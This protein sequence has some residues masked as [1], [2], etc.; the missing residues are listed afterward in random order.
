MPTDLQE[1]PVP[2]GEISQ[3]PNAFEEFLDRNQKNL[4]L[5]SILLALA[6]A[7]YVIYTGI[8]QS[9]QDTA[10]AAL[11]EADK[12]AELQAVIQQ[13]S[14]TRAAGSATVLLADRQWDEGQQDA[15]IESL[16][17]FV[18]SH[19]DH[20]ARP[21]AQASLGAKLMAQGKSADATTVFQEIVDEPGARYI[22]PYALI[23]LGDL[24]FAAGDIDKAETFYKRVTTD[25]SESDFVN[26]ATAR[27]ASLRTKAP[28][29]IEPPAKPATAETPSDPMEAIKA[30]LPSG[31]TVSSSEA[32]KA[33]ETAAPAE[34]ESTPQETPAETTPSQP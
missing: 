7:G 13:N 18:T 34:N 1:Q 26:T 4:I 31:V 8:E 9:K 11:S 25:F 28:V 16:R 10:G 12:L 23:S 33:P 6:A 15:A 19:P 27:I 20:P 30:A 5:L 2:L 14:G 3:G 22:A 32:P 29:E 24:A 17:A 21:A